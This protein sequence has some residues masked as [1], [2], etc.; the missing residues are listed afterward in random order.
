MVADRPFKSLVT[1]DMLI[2]LGRRLTGPADSFQGVA[3]ATW[4]L[5][6]LR[7][8]YHSIDVGPGGLIRILHPDGQVLFREPSSQDPIG[9]PAL[10]DPVYLA[11][12][13]ES[14]GTARRRA[15]PRWTPP[16]HGLPYAALAGIDCGFA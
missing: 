3:V 14:R 2:P 6:Q 9:E 5:P 12:G 16:H 13:P 10:K 8:F 7:A 1:G 15:R 11:P 4:R